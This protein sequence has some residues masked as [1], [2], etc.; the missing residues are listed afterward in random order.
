MRKSVPI[1]WSLTRDV[2]FGVLVFGGL[3]LGVMIFATRTAVQTLSGSL[4]A[5]T[6]SQAEERLARFFEPVEHELSVLSQRGEQGGLDVLAADA[7]AASFAPVIREYP[8]VSSML[9]ADESGNEFML[10]RSQDGWLSRETRSGEWEGRSRLTS[11]TDDEESQRTSEWEDLEYDP[12]S[13]PWFRGAV[14]S[15]DRGE[16]NHWTEPY[17]FFTT[18]DLGISAS[19]SFMVDGRRHVIALDV[20]LD[21]I[22]A[23]TTQLQIRFGGRAFVLDE[24]WR[25]IGLPADPRFATTAS[26]REYLLR[27]PSEL[28]LGAA[29]DAQAIYAERPPA[30]T[31]DAVR[32]H[33]AGS[34][35]WAD[36][37]RYS[38]SSE[39]HL[40]IAVLIPESEMLRDLGD[41][42]IWVG[43]LTLVILGVA[44][45]RA[46]MVAGR[47]SHPIEQLV[48]QSDRFGRGDL[49]D[50]TSIESPVQEVRLLAD[51]HE[52]MRRA[53]RAL[54][55]L[56]GDLRIARQIQQATI[57]SDLPRL[58]GWDLGAWNQP[59]D[60]TGG[61]MYDAFIA[62]PDD[63]E[64]RQESGAVLMLADATGHGIGPSLS[65]TQM[66]SMLRMG[67]RLGAT[68]GTLLHHLNEQLHRDLPVGR[69]V[70]AWTGVVREGSSEMTTFSAG[71]GPLLFYRS[72]TDEVER[73]D[74]DAPPL[75]VL[76]TLDVDA[77]RTF[78]FDAGDML[79]VASDGIFEAANEADEM[80][81]EE[82]VIEIVREARHSS[83]QEIIS[84]LEE[85]VRRFAGGRAQ[86][87]DQTV[88]IVKR[89]S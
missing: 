26:R 30:Q 63:T 81:G 13:R 68:P 14:Q 67:V 55:K 76:D 64:A 56:E 21:D 52:H 80:F 87:D 38:L 73:Y 42:R 32:F 15:A 85:R 25:T 44:T 54:I 35:W 2:V 33:S 72:A 66:R 6:I 61:D 48:A 20:L 53:L 11:W 37:S 31:S 1:R 70:T 28:D 12:T 51:A 60:E 88:M 45:L 34:V 83:A 84:I 47:F 40:W 89:R 59:A 86:I 65:A 27:Q 5:A 78:S 58:D 82:R 39:R 9:L 10:L 29:A 16:P 43:G 75:G 19:R 79:V 62:R 8:Q 22:S 36:A 7:L 50:T 57:P 77:M 17:V 3:I 74:A 69:F 46:I 24:D 4:T 71:Q 49:D 23:F 41:T 18:K